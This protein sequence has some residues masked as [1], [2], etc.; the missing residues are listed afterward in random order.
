MMNDLSIYRD[1]LKASNRGVDVK[2]FCERKGISRTTFYTIK[3]RIWNGDSFK[4][5]ECC[6]KSRL[7]CLWE[8]RYKHLLALVR[9][10]ARVGKD[11]QKDFIRIINR[12]S[13]DGFPIVLI[14]KKLKVSRTLV[15]HYLKKYD[16]KV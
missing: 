9:P 2:K 4:I 16:K 11:Q 5:K 14:V 3:K 10:T 13:K 6:R 15:N 1:Y 12:M 8:N 7:E